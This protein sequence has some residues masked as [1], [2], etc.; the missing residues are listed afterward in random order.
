[1]GLRPEK[2]DK[3]T[4]SLGTSLPTC[5]ESD[6]AAHSLGLSSKISHPVNLDR[7]VSAPASICSHKPKADSP[8]TSDKKECPPLLDPPQ[9]SS[10]CTMDDQPPDFPRSAPILWNSSKETIMADD[11]KPPATEST[12]S[13]KGSPDTQHKEDLSAL[14]T[15][16]PHTQTYLDK[17]DSCSPCQEPSQGT[18]PQ[19]PPQPVG[20]RSKAELQRELG[21]PQLPWSTE[22]GSE[23]QPSLPPTQQRSDNSQT[24]NSGAERSMPGH[25]QA[26][27]SAPSSASFG[28]S[29]T[30]TIME[31][32]VAEQS[33]VAVHSLA[34][35]HSTG[36]EDADASDLTFDNPWVEAEASKPNSS[37]VIVS[38][39]V[40]A[41]DLQPPESNVEMSETESQLSYL[42]RENC[43]S[44]SLSGDGLISTDP[45]APT[46]ESA[47]SVTAALKELH[48]L[49]VI[50][51]QESPG[52]LTSEEVT[53]PKLKAAE[54]RIESQEKSEQPPQSQHPPV[55][56]QEPE[57]Q[58][59]SSQVRLGPEKAERS[60]QVSSD[61]EV[62]SGVGGNVD[63]SVAAA[64]GDIQKSQELRRESFSFTGTSVETFGQLNSVG[65]EISSRH[66][67]GEERTIPETSQQT[68]ALPSDFLPVLSQD[69]LTGMPDTRESAVC[70][71]ATRPLHRLEQLVSPPASS[72]SPLPSHLFPAAD[73]DR[74][75]QAGFSLRE[76]LGALQ[77]VG[78]D[79]DLALLIL[80]AKNI[81]VPT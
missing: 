67:A 73:V 16:V 10:D 18:G 28:S 70:P 62:Q 43:S 1:M 49:L 54:D 20:E 40:S 31:I 60:T 4:T 13:I 79:V 76:A 27:D 3:E 59:S 65:T 11:L 80:L 35:G 61:A 9:A 29:F 36:T 5:G 15:Q 71:E 48:Q 51:C 75:L 52:N 25:P 33:V 34:S 21:S 30:E 17:N 81:I 8:V 37:S 12:C 26:E 68:E 19:Q 44:L 46:E 55:V 58:G 2:S 22:F 45:A 38:N 39:P 7:S 53:H 64:P 42:L 14:A 56:L 72:P 78:G 57:S 41:S 63:E 24:E 47:L 74:I 32:D 6:S 23:L 69:P 66:L 50:S 77:R